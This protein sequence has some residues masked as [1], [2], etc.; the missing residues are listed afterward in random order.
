METVL[1]W[2]SNKYYIF[3]ICVYSLSHPACN[4][5]AS[6]CHL[7]PVRLY[8]IFSHCLINGTGFEKVIEYELFVLQLLSEKFLILRRIDRDI[9]NLYRSSY[10]VTVIRVQFELNLKFLGR[11]SKKYSNIKFHKNPSSGSRVVPCRR[12]DGQMDTHDEVNCRFLKFYAG[13]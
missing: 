6:Y 7:W 2:A 9:K 10:K 4:A 11:F 3:W 1:L 13:A 8:N 5:H 12:T